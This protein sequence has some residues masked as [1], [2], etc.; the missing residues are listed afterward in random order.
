MLKGHKVTYSNCNN[1]AADCPISLKFRIEF[2]RGEARLL[3]MF[4]DKGQGH[5]VKVQGHSVT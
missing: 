4:K 1:S 2:D 5:G 3:H